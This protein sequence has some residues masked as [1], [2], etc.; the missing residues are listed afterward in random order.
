MTTEFPKWIEFMKDMF[1]ISIRVQLKGKNNLFKLQLI[2]SLFRDSTK[3][4]F[5]Y[6]RSYSY[7]RRMDASLMEEWLVPNMCRKSCASGHD[8]QQMCLNQ[9]LEV[10]APSK[11]LISLFMKT[12]SFT[13]FADIQSK[14]G[15]DSK[16]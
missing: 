13:E 3:T 4:D 11:Q 2:L 7:R 10:E 9:K 8:F 6:A 16:I 15:I 14:P 1:L 5:T 12:L